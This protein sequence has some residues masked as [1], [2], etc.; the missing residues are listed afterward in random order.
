MDYKM[1][2]HIHARLGFRGTDNPPYLRSRSTP[3]KTDKPS[4]P[5]S[6]A[7]KAVSQQGGAGE[8]GNV[9]YLI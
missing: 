3:K 6:D 2:M 8:H 9:P 7:V 4:K 1:M 5:S